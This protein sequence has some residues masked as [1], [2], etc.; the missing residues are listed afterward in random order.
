MD[1]EPC[2]DEEACVDRLGSRTILSRMETGGTE[3]NL[4]E[5]RNVNNSIRDQTRLNSTLSGL[6]LFPIS[7]LMRIPST[8]ATMFITRRALSESENWVRLLADTWPLELPP[9]SL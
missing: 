8:V 3:E 1:V 9:R 6:G 5:S 7:E 2:E 4:L